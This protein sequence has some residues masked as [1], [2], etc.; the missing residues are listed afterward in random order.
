MFEAFKDFVFHE[1]G[2]Y[3]TCKDKR[4]DISTT[5]FIHQYAKDFDVEKTAERVANREGRTVTNVLNEWKAENLFSTTKGTMIHELAQAMWFGRTYKPNFEVEGV[6][7]DRLTTAYCKSYPLVKKF[8]TDKKTFYEAVAEELVVGS[9]KYNIAGSVDLLLRHKVYDKYIMIDFKTNKEIKK[10]GFK[11]AKMKIPIHHLN[12]CNFV[13]YSMQL[14]IYKHL[15]EEYT[16][17]KIAKSFIVH[18][19]EY[20]DDYKMFEPLKLD[21]EIDRLLNMRKER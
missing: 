21:Y 15:I 11:G 14:G 18:F 10:E 7:K 20:E 8:F 6:D 12:D 13:H 17:I 3:Y 4:I 9:E 5:Q 2:H 16:P 1:D 19:D